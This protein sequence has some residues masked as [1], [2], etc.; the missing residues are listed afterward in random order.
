MRAKDPDGRRRVVSQRAIIRRTVTVF[1]GVPVRGYFVWSLLDN[2]EWALGFS[3][4]FGLVHID[5]GTFER[6]PKDSF[7]FYA[8]LAGGA[9]LERE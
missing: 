4:R 9:A 5:Y 7:H 3:R 2:F 8:E 6:R 1:A